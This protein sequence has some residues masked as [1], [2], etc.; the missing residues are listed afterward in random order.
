[1]A[2]SI[3]FWKLNP[4][5]SPENITKVAAKIM[6]KGLFP[7][8]GMEILGWYICPGGKGVTITESKTIDPAVAF[9]NWLVWVQE[10]TGFFEC[11]EVLPAVS[12][13]EAMQ[14]VL[15]KKKK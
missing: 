5:I 4:D 6:E 1:M 2:I 9:K 13:Q 14:M 8:E 10:M 7:P 11:Y 3:T 12:A 15:E